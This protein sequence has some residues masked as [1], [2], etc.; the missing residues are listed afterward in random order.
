MQITE[1]V[2]KLFLLF[3][4]GV[5]ATLMLNQLSANKITKPFEFFIYSAVLGI[6]TIIIMEMFYSLYIVIS[7]LFLGN[8]K[9]LCWGTNLE[10][11]NNIFDGDSR[12][13]K[14]EIIL[15][16]IL[17]IPLGLLYGYL[18]SK[19]LINKLFQRLKLSNRYGD[20]DIWCY[21]FSA[22]DV[23]WV[24]L[25][26]KTSNLTYYGKLRAGSDTE[27]RREIVLEEVSVYTSDT[28]KH[29]YDIQT[30]Y[31]ELDNY[32]FSIESPKK[33]IKDETNE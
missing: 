11:W 27:K 8:L 31:L 16:Y 26:D 21:F 32:S 18:G 20:N 19:N 17:S 24:F 13:N 9:N 14:V 10:I 28:S 22:V 1:L 7:S 29:L 23:D 15:S 33:Q 25:R 4:P 2:W 3:L 5:V 12:F 6:A 30:I